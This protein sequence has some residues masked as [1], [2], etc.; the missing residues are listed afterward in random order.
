MQSAYVFDSTNMAD[1]YKLLQIGCENTI[2]KFTNK[3]YSQ[4]IRWSMYLYYQSVFKQCIPWSVYLYYQSVFTKCIQW[5][6][7]MYH[8]S[9]FTSYIIKVS[10]LYFVLAGYICIF[11]T[12]CI[13]KVYPLD[14][15]IL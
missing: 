3:V 10:S 13:L 11:P 5:I 4:C 2:A 12:Q 9:V 1:Q 6:V 14:L 8:Q 15:C 7:Y